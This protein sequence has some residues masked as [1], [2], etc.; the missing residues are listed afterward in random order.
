[1]KFIVGEAC[2][3][4]EEVNTDLPNN[5]G[6]LVIVSRIKKDSPN[7]QYDVTLPSGDYV[8]VKEKEINKLTERQREYMTYIHKDNTVIYIPTNEE[9]IIQKTDYLHGQVSIMFEDGG[10]TTVGFE[11]VR[12]LVDK[13]ETKATEDTQ[14]KFT[15]LALKIGEF[16][17]MKNKQYGSS[18]DATYSMIKV[19]MERYKNNDNTYTIPESLLQHIL[20]QVRMMDKL[21]RVFNNP[22]GKG[23]SESP[24]NDITGYGLIGVDMVSKNK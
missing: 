18:V 22:S 17:D 23:D 24:Y 19:L 10:A 9:V 13:S 4:N 2:Y 15:S 3:L 5:T 21:N 16:T 14:G 20:L 7:Y 12:E 6:D 8:P 1:M 11:S